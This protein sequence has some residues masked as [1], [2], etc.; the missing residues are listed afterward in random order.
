MEVLA[1]RKGCVRSLQ[2]QAIL[3]KPL[4]QIGGIGLG[5]YP[6]FLHFRKDRLS[7]ALQMPAR[8]LHPSVV[9]VESGGGGA[10]QGGDPKCPTSS[11]LTFWLTSSPRTGVHVGAETVSTPL[12]VTWWHQTPQPT[13]FR[14]PSPAHVDSD[15]LTTFITQGL[16]WDFC[17]GFG[18]VFLIKI[19]HLML[20][21]AP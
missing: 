11:F 2:F 20:A 16:G 5:Q 8:A 13:S 17:G 21:I 10:G 7:S 4:K 3:K 15:S 19:K 9:V 6:D 1:E 12:R 18:V 14:L